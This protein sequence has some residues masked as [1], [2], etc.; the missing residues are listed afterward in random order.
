[1][2]KVGSRITIR[3]GGWVLIVLG[4]LILSIIVWAVAPAVFRLGNHGPGDGSDVASYQFDLSNLHIP[5]ETLV[6]VMQHRDMS[7]VLTNPEILNAEELA[8]KNF[9]KRKQFLVSG[10]LVVGLEI[11]GKKRTYPLHMLNVHEVINDTLGGIPITVY[12][13]WPSG[14]LGV[15]ER[16][17]NGE[18]VSFGLSGLSGNGSMLLY[19]MTQQV[20]GEQLFSPILSTSVTGESILL[21]P[22]AH[23][24]TSWKEW[25]TKNPQTT[26]VAPN[27]QFKKRYRKGDPRQ[28]FLNDTIYFPVSEMPNDT[29]NP[30][31]HVIIVKTDSGDVVYAIQD[32]VDAAGESGEITLDVSGSPITFTVGTAPLFAVAKGPNGNIVATKRS[33]WFT[34]YANH[35]DAVISSPISD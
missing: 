24:V 21:Q 18:E 31:T 9:N 27:E 4:V 34:W 15:F 11:N 1:M 35:P 12:W 19:P 10:D 23:E 32:L 30:K 5:E 14:Y 26:C 8:R 2:S 3:E 20:G 25:F 17:I 22:I 6:A 7:P 16:V 33:L 13:N 28:Y 29:I